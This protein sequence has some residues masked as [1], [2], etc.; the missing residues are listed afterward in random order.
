MVKLILNQPGCMKLIVV[1]G[2]MNT[3]RKNTRSKKFSS[4][5]SVGVSR[6]YKEYQIYE[7]VKAPL[8]FFLILEV[9]GWQ[10]QPE[11]TVG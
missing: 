10:K 2:S 4:P 1:P 7:Q 8:I 5:C 11:N 9:A 3:P 6:N